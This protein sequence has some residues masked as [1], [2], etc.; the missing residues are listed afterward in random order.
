MMERRLLPLG[1]KN[2]T[3]TE[4]PALVAL[5]AIGKPWFNENHRADLMAIALVSKLLAAEGSY[6]HTIAGELMLLLEPDEL[7]IDQVRPVVMDINTWLQI[8]PNGR[9][10]SAIDKLMR[11]GR[12][13]TT[14]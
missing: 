10:D 6:I 5:Q 7:N 9:V 4:L 13:N 8:Q 3:K 1:I 11:Q 12:K 14:K 2:H